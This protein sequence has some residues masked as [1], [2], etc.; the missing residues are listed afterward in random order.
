MLAR[1]KMKNFFDSNGINAFLAV[2]A[3]KVSFSLAEVN[4]WLST[5]TA[6]FVLIYTA[7]LAFLSVLRFIREAR[8]GNAEKTR[9]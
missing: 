7:S 4:E 3:A 2:I 1:A 9:K 6:A 8:S 5:L